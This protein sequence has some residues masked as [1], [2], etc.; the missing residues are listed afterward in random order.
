MVNRTLGS[1]REKSEKISAPLSYKY[2]ESSIRVSDDPLSKVKEN[3]VSKAKDDP[4]SNIK[5]NPLS[6]ANE[7]PL[8][9]AKKS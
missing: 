6:K 9:K 2:G 3:P 8:S 7:N 4:I 1:H 5:E